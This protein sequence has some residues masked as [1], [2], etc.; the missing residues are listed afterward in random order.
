MTT[1]DQN[2]LPTFNSLEA[3]TVWAAM[4][5][6]QLYPTD[7]TTEEV[8]QA[9]Q[10]VAQINALD[11]PIPTDNDWTYTIN[12][13]AVIRLSLPLSDTWKLGKLWQGVDNLGTSATPT[14]YY[15]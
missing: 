5:L 2:S 14:E 8:G 1:F 6:S 12:R 13:R 7:K 11:F 4:I 15:S 9:P 3:L 10:L